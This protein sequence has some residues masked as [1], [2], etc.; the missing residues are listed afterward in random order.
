MAIPFFKNNLI[1]NL[2]F[3]PTWIYVS[4]KIFYRVKEKYFYFSAIKNE[5]RM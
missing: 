5:K 3:A 4:S 2:I 1:G